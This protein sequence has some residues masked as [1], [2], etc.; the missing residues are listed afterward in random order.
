MPD[1]RLQLT[2]IA[3]LMALQPPRFLFGGW[4][5]DA[6]LH[7][8][9]SRPHDDIDLLV[10]L[11]ELDDLL[12]QAAGLGFVDARVKFQVE[13]GKPIVVAA[14]AEGQELELIV[15][16]TDERGRAFFDLPVGDGL[17]R[18]WMPADAFGHPPGRLGKLPVRTLS[19]LALYQVRE[20]C[21]H[22]FGGFRDKDRKTQAALK[23][24]Y[25][26]DRTEAELRTTGH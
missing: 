12:A 25:F 19:P 16:Q 11:E 21:Q 2:A 20:F 14:Y 10:P 8:K 3:S 24:R 6:L 23:E 15:Y 1:E 4:A 22:V 26:R 9:P 17:Q 18:F 7:G 5:E 13:D